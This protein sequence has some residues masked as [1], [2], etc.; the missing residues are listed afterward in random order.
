TSFMVG[1]ENTGQWIKRSSF[2]ELKVLASLLGRSLGHAKSGHKANFASYA[3]A[4]KL[5]KMGQGEDLF[6]S[7]CDSCHSLGNED[8]LWP[9]LQGVTQC[10]DKARLAR[11]IKTPDKLLAEKDPIAIE[12]YNRYNKILMPNLRLNDSDV[13][14]LIKYMESTSKRPY[15]AI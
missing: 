2:D 12:L 14:G 6:R 13:E 7:H 3:S 5:P 4:E 1:N 9:G 15:D 10:R 8:G 11:W